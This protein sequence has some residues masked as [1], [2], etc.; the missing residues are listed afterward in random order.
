MKLL[1]RRHSGP[2]ALSP[3]KSVKQWHLMA[4]RL[5]KVI[6]GSPM[7]G[8]VI[9]LPRALMLALSLAQGLMLL[10][11]WRASEA[12]VWPS[13]DTD[14]EL[15]AGHLRAQLADLAAVH[16]GSWQH[17][18]GLRV[19]ERGE[20]PLG[21][22]RP[23]RRVAGVA[24]RCLFG[25]IPC[26]GR[27]CDLAGGRVQGA[28]VRGASRLGRAPR[29]RYAVSPLMAQL[30][31][32]GTGGGAKRWLSACCC[33]FGRPCSTSSASSSS[34]TCSPRIG[35]SFPCSRLPSASA[36]WCSAT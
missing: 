26:G 36:C 24:D 16:I 35:F 34:P 19:G 21:A 30:S 23:L 22:L 5:G 20:R 11:L 15:C 9:R 28:D 18:P 6:A 31:G 8:A 25:G 10:G 27:H 12:G 14:L 17:P 32:G 33:G 7:I 29:L 2:P 3:C 13:P 4:H 1:Y